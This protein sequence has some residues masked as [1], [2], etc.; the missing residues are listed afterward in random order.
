VAE[1][2]QLPKGVPPSQGPLDLFVSEGKSAQD[3]VHESRLELVPEE[4]LL[5]SHLS[6]ALVWLQAL[7]GSW[8]SQSLPRQANPFHSE[9]LRFLQLLL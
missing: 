6:E 3:G 2:S 5:H 9:N 7:H 1:V 8:A 4:H